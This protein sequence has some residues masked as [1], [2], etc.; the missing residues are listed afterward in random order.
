MN[1]AQEPVR[2]SVGFS[3]LI[4][5]ADAGLVVGFG[6]STQSVWTYSLE[7]NTWTSLPPAG[8]PRPDYLEGMVYDP[9]S[10]S[11]LLLDND[12]AS[13]EAPTLWSYQV[14]GNTWTEI[15]QGGT[16]PTENPVLLGLHWSLTYDS[17][18]GQL[19]LSLFG[20]DSVGTGNQTWTFDP[21][22]G[23]WAR[24]EWR[25]PSFNFGYGGSVAVFDEAAGRTVVFSDGV[26][27]L[28]DAASDRWE[29]ITDLPGWPS[30]GPGW[31]VVETGPLARLGHQL[32][33]DGVNG[34]V[35]MLG[36]MARYEDGWR[37]EAD[38]IWALDLRRGEWI[39]LL[40]ATG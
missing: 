3:E 12:E 35:V 21:D 31:P 11:I 27:G 32:V 19:V 38:D 7:S 22:S 39:E 33:Y 14:E 4:Y 25:S 8:P 30:P 2:P 9:Q 20:H 40:A 1:P 24:Q 5:D 6:A 17:A 13:D 15:D 10:G 16:A 28:Y 26:V 37:E 23:E 36:G 34:R 18:V 29:R